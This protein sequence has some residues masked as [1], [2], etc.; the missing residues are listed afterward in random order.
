M[1]ARLCRMCTAPITHTENCGTKPKR[2]ID[3]ERFAD[4]LDVGLLRK[5]RT[6]GDA[7]RSSDERSIVRD[8]ARLS[9]RTPKNAEQ[10][11]G[12]GSTGDAGSTGSGLPICW[13]LDFYESAGLRATP[14]DRAMNARLCSIVHGSHRAHRKTRNKAKV[15]DRRAT[16]LESGAVCRSA[17]RWISKKRR[18]SGP[19][20]DRSDERSI[21]RDVHGSHRAHR[22][23]G[24][25]P[26]CRID[27]RRRSNRER[28]AD[29]LYESAGLAG[30]AAR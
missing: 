19:T 3:R 26:K 6:E 5:R 15:P 25:K 8:C 23:R 29:L 24:T 4:L 27:G 1:N 20:L 22:T 2:R 28:S 9:S 21:V 17:G 16:P 12:A 14:L 18:N 13:T 7:A 11:Q 10:S 30:Y